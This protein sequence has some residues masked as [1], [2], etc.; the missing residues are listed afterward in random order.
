MNKTEKR[1]KNKLQNAGFC[2]LFVEKYHVLT[3]QNGN[4]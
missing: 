1:C 3:R 4:V 2:V